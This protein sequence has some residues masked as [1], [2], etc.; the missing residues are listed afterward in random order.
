MTI[1]ANAISWIGANFT[2]G[3]YLFF[4]KAQG[5]LWSAAD[6]ILVLALLKIAD[7]ARKREGEKKIVFRYALLWISAILTPLLVFCR[8]PREFFFLE[9]ILCGIQFSLLIY[10]VLAERGRAARVLKEIA[11]G[12]T[13]SGTRPVQGPHA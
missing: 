1:T 7:L 13:V 5:I 2:S 9:C 6:I 10:T 11:G 12:H 4:S 8:T 3:H